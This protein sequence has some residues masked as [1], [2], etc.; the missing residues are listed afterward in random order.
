MNTVIVSKKGRVLIPNEIMEKYNIKNGDKI[1]FIDYGNVISLIPIS[2]DGI[3]SSAGILKS[4]KSLT[5]LLL[6][7]RKKKLRGKTTF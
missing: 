3:N 6:E 5:K 2:K 7:D 1:K 4:K